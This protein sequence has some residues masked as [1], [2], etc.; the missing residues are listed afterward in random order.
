[1]DLWADSDSVIIIDAVRS[2]G[3]SGAIYRIDALA[4]Q[5]PRRLFLCSTHAL[6]LAEAIEL[7][8]AMDRLPARLIIYG[9]E[10]RD[11]EPGIGLSPEVERAAREVAARIQSECLQDNGLPVT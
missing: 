9:I 8:R 5:L 10:G 4:E 6:G 2:G 3:E 1:M 11:F 7:A